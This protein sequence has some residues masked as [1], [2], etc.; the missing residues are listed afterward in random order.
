MS[1]DRLSPRRCGVSFVRGAAKVLGLLGRESRLGL[2]PPCLAFSH[3][4][5]AIREV[6]TLLP[7]PTHR[8]P[9]RTVRR[10]RP[11]SGQ[12][13]QQK[14]TPWPLASTTAGQVY[15]VRLWQPLI[16]EVI[17]DLD[18]LV[19]HP[20]AAGFP[21]YFQGVFREVFP[22]PT[23]LPDTPI[24]WPWVEGPHLSAREDTNPIAL[25]FPVKSLSFL[26]TSPKSSLFVLK[27][28]DWTLHLNYMFASQ[29]IESLQSV[30]GHRGPTYSFYTFILRSK[31]RKKKKETWRTR[32]PLRRMLYQ[33]EAKLKPYR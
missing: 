4:T 28:T 21:R 1:A 26:T 22:T 18:L 14:V 29:Q 7:P 13:W 3:F 33:A 30:L 5:K 24:G 19:P 2:L 15:R 16:S 27:V 31:E 32:D 20:D 9:Q 12:W 8:S 6:P 17:A 23:T 25:T 10:R 11:S